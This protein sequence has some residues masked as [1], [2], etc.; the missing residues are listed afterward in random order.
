MQVS[1]DNKSKMDLAIVA[2]LIEAILR[3]DIDLLLANTIRGCAFK[4]PEIGI[5]I[6]LL[7]VSKEHPASEFAF[8]VTNYKVEGT[9]Q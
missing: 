4:F 9:D 8:L 6:S 1:F 3:K 5:I 7:P 2:G